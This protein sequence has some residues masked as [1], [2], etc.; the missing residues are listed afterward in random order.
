MPLLLRYASWVARYFRYHNHEE[1]FIILP[2]NKARTVRAC[3][4]DRAKAENLPDRTK[5]HQ[6]PQNVYDRLLP[7]SVLITGA[8]ATLPRRQRVTRVPIA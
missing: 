7:F 1:D 5:L 2:H 6:R 4:A 8:V 3:F